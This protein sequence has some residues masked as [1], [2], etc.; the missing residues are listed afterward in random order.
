MTGKK[1]PGKYGIAVPGFAD[2]QRGTT[3]N[4]KE[5]PFAPGQDPENVKTAEEH[6]EIVAKREEG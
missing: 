5:G 1:S 3:G 6:E 2:V 4:P